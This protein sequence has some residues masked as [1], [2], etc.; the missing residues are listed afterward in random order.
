MEELLTNAI[1]FY[2]LKELQEIG[3][4]PPAQCSAGPVNESDCK[5]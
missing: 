5:L 4:D 2:H 1:F 3:R